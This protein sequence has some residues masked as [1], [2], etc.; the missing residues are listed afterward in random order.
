MPTLPIRGRESEIAVLSA[1]VDDAVRGVGGVVVI[2]GEA[3]V[4]K[5]RLLAEASARALGAGV[6]VAGG[7]AHQLGSAAPLAPLLS[8]LSGGDPPVLER[9]EVQSLERPG[10]QRYWLVEDLVDLLERRAAEQ[11]ILVML[12]DLQWADDATAW[13]LSMLGQRLRTAPVAW[14]L[15]ARVPLVNT[16]IRDALAE[17]ARNGAARLGLTHL[18]EADMFALAADALGGAPD[19][20]L[21]SLVTA[22][23]GNPFLGLELLRGFVADDLVRVDDGIATLLEARVPEQ[24]RETTRGRLAS[25]SPMARDVL[26]VGAVLGRTFSV[27]DTA[28]VLD[29]P[30]GGLFT[31]VAEALSVDLLVERGDRMEFRHDL[32]RE[33][34]YDDIP[35]PTRSALHRAAASM[36]V[37]SGGA[38]TE[39]ATHLMTVAQP[40]DHEASA[41]LLAAAGAIA[42]HS[43]GPAADLAARAVEL[44]PEEQPGWT[45][46]VVG[47]VQLLAWASR[48]AEADALAAR[49]LARRLP[50]EDEARV[51]LGLLDS[52]LLSARRI[53]LVDQCRAALAWP[54]LPESFR[55]GFLHDLGQGLAQVGDIEAAHQAYLDGI[56]AAGPSDD[57]LVYS[58][59]IGMSLTE[60]SLGYMG[61]ARTRIETCVQQAEVGTPE[62]QRRMP[63]L[64]HSVVLA[65]HDQ[66]DDAERAL[67][68]ARRYA[69]DVGASWAE[70]F[71]QRIVCSLRFASGRIDDAI[72]EAE[73]SLDLIEA[74]DMWFDSDSA[75]GV[76]ALSAFH[77]NELRRAREYLTQSNAYRPTYSHNPI[78]YLQLADALVADALGDRDRAE[79]M[80]EEVIEN[81]QALVQSMAIEP[82][83][84]PMLVRLATRLVRN[85][86]LGAAVVASLTRIVEINDDVPLYRS[87]EMHARGLVRD[88]V[89][90]LVAAADAFAASPR[91]VAR[92]S[93]FE[94]AGRALVGSADPQRGIAYL[95]TA[96]EDYERAG[97]I[98]DE[99]R[100]RARLRAVGVRRRS[101]ADTASVRPA[102][103]W[104]ALT[105][106]EERVARS[107]AAGHTN[108]EIAGELYLSPYTVATH[109]KHIFSKLGIRSRVDLVR[110]AVEHTT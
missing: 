25:L 98:R 31:V 86:N 95:S 29:R 76:L 77:R 1:V 61:D 90:L 24:L 71:T 33:A 50:P 99:A 57:E 66:F 68:A 56:A 83:Q 10:D 43:P 45:E 49:A 72:A 28:V 101:H 59:E 107:A 5:T 22:A 84:G 54:D 70:E 39:A 47:T 106:A 88:D 96:R 8:A 30:V 21:R 87:C 27:A 74:L 80:L 94:D 32:L 2:E 34:V 108:R 110:I 85:G 7:R 91:L 13:A 100:V 36:I 23:E 14:V 65:V 40:G 15:A 9:R 26:Y 16:V 60:G 38:P 20:R 69:N 104:R 102:T 48:F 79:R 75:F 52:L 41:V 18:G 73:A 37:A 82:T 78:E 109:M 19:A 46:I 12:D 42:A 58:C 81:E 4:G 6:R 17:Y 3:G 62:Q 51:R 53:E 11:P 89:P 67:L 103:G 97:A 35:R 44:L 63:W 105:V 92:A 64:W 55:S 93:A